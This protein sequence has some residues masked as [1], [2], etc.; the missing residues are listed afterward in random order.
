MTAVVDVSDRAQV[1]AWIENT[2]ASFGRPLDGAA[3]LAGI[4]QPDGRSVQGRMRNLSE[5]VVDRVMNL[6]FKGVVNCMVAELN[7]LKEG[8]SGVGGGSIVNCAS[9]A[10]HMGLEGNPAYTAAKHAVVGLTRTA[11]KEEGT[12]GIRVNAVSPGTVQT[13][14]V[15]AVDRELDQSGQRWQE[16]SA[17]GRRAQPE[18]VAKLIMFLLG[19]DSSYITGVSY[20]IDGGWI[21]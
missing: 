8:S 16:M 11:A 21:C 15:E 4:S 6:N 20:L 18:E 1:F 19:D 13:P 12:K 17:L 9:V 10:W 3:N 7:H 2:V 14:M 5:E